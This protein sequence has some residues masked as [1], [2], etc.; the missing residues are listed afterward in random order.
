MVGFPIGSGHGFLSCP[1]GSGILPG[2]HYQTA[3]MTKG[4]V[5]QGMTA[6]LGSP[7]PAVSGGVAPMTTKG[8]MAGG[9]VVGGCKGL[10]LG[11]GVGLGFWGPLV[12]AGL[13]A[14]AA[15]TIWKSRQAV[16]ALS[17]DDQEFR[18]ALAEK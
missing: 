13:G 17:E 14:A 7:G 4:C 18:D 3:A 11:L 2:L 10:S 12:L 15:F 16:E 8:I 1:A 9:S 6:A 5:A